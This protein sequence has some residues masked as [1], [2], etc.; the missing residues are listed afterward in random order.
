MSSGWMSL[1]TRT[2][3]W[4]D[5]VQVTGAAPAVMRN[6]PEALYLGVREGGYPY[7]GTIYEG[8]GVRRSHLGPRPRI[9]ARLPEGEARTSRGLLVNSDVTIS[10]ESAAFLLD[11]LNRQQLNA[12]DPNLAQTA[13]LV[14]RVRTELTGGAE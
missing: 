11:L 9:A 7:L 5:E 1:G 2:D 3:L 12:G 13:A 4:V 14:V 8:A 10:A 6:V